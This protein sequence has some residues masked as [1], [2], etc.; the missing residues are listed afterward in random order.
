MPTCRE[1]ALLNR[2]RD[3]KPGQ[4]CGI[5]RHR[6]PLAYPYADVESEACE[7]FE[8]LYEGTL[9][10]DLWPL[11]ELPSIE[12]RFCCVC[13]KT[14]PL[15]Q[16]HIVRRGAGQ[17]YKR[18]QLMEKPSITLCGTGTSGCHGLAH[19]NRLHF[20]NWEGQLQFRLFNEPT[21]YAQA[22]KQRGW[23]PVRLAPAW[24][25]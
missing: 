20:R 2:G 18:G 3:L 5:C 17:L 25:E 13:G 4:A 8:P 6:E 24:E 16:H 7:E 9:D 11:M 14:Y 22:I 15:N 12:Q 23:R 19:S 10:H 1:C 21:K